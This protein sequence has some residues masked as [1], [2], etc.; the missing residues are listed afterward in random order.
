[1]NKIKENINEMNNIEIKENILSLNQKQL[2]NIKKASYLNAFHSIIGVRTL[3]EDKLSKDN[4][5][6]KEE[7][8]FYNNYIENLINSIRLSMEKPK[9]NK[10]T[11]DD[12]KK[13]RK[14][15]YE[16]YSLAGG[17]LIELSYLGELI[18]EYGIK[19][20]AKR[21][22][23]NTNYDTKIID[24]LISTINQVLTDKKDNYSEYIYIISEIVH[25]L[26]MK[27]TRNNYHN[28]IKETLV[29]NLKTYNKSE[30]E[31]QIN[32]YKKKFDSSTMDGYGTRLDY[33][34][35]E[36]QKLKN[37]NLEGKN[38]EDLSELVNKNVDLNKEINEFINIVLMLGLISN[39]NIVISLT[40]DVIIDPKIEE[41]FN[42][43]VNLLESKEDKEIIKFANK[44][45][46]EIEIVENDILRD[47][48]EFQIINME[49]FNRENFQYDDLDKELIYTK[50]ILTY[51]NDSIFKDIDIMFPKNEEVSNIEYV[52]QSVDSLIQYMNRSTVDM[53]NSERRIRMRKLLSIIELPF[54][55]I[56]DFLNYIKYS[57]DKRVNSK[58]EVNF[59][60][61][62]IKYFLDEF[63]KL[64]SPKDIE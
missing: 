16:M 22:Y 37:I 62:H 49:G 27:L 25:I 14:E 40:D 63:L 8:D 47:L 39:M 51:Y 7:I 44:I 38:L 53:D 43:W 45:E 41:I 33:Y 9:D 28:I 54:S 26:P 46:K 1:M 35:R 24:G 2:K 31:V 13:L 29:R 59:K 18:D 12:L 42:E 3:L 19:I 17:Y 20:L 23:A 55:G 15:I 56:D 50:K 61:N 6:F 30:L 52:E 32:D 60:I 36:I 10:D 11:L 34:F 5:E 48:E 58:E 4:Y 21:D 57:L 64:T